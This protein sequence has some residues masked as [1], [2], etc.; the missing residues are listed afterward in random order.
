MQ[1]ENNTVASL[2]YT[3]KNGKGELLDKADAQQPF[4]YLHGANNVVVGLE[5][6]LAGKTVGDTLT[7]VVPPKEGYGLRDDRLTQEIPRKMFENMNET[8]L[9]AGAQFEAQTDAG[10]EIIT[11]VKVSN[12]T[13]N[14]DANHPLADETLHFDIEVLSLRA[15]TAEEISHGHAHA[16]GNSCTTEHKHK[17]KDKAKADGVGESK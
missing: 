14:I 1:I 10:R 3:L 12:D 9:V 6:H 15:A 2:R 11:I 4:V 5:K 16:A 17:D 8:M 7:A 13:I